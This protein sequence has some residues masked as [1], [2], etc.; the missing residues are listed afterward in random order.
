MYELKKKF[1]KVFT[2]EFVGT[3]PSSY[4]KKKIPGRDL[5]KVENHCSRSV[6]PKVCFADPKGIQNLCCLE[7]FFMA[8]SMLKKPLYLLRTCIYKQ[9]CVIFTY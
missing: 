4:E 8:I 2:S 1:G 9:Y 3:G 5:T 7:N 6:V